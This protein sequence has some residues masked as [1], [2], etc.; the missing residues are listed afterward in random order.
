MKVRQ[1]ETGNLGVSGNFNMQALAEIIV[2]FDEGDM[3]TMYISDFD[4]YLEQKEEWKDLSQAF[5]DR[6]VIT[7]NYNTRFFEPSREEDRK[8]GYT[9]N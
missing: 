9:I 3:D 8:R 6:D 5:K 1:K 2:G 4:T 7:D